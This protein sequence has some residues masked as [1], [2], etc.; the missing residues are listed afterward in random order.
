MNENLHF[1]FFSNVANNGTEVFELV[2]HL[3]PFPIPFLNEFN[4]VEDNNIVGKAM[5]QRYL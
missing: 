5:P 1:E 4:I 3:D 2:H